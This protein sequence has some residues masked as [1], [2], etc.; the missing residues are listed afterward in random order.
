MGSSMD[1]LRVLQPSGPVAHSLPPVVSAVFLKP[2]LLQTNLEA[3]STINAM[4][5]F[6]W[7]AERSRV[8]SIGFLTMFFFC[9]VTFPI[10][11]MYAIY[12]DIYH[13]NIPQMLAYM[14][15]PWILWDLQ[16]H[17]SKNKSV[18]IHGEHTRYDI[19]G[20]DGAQPKADRCG[21][22]HRGIER[23]PGRRH[24]VAGLV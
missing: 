10:G 9:L 3:D 22:G 6:G 19:A 1:Q 20:A 13:H 17:D 16:K 11:S 18:A 15:A 5:V 23:G 8:L 7:R 14:P 2:G 12:G 4:G 24:G 21:T